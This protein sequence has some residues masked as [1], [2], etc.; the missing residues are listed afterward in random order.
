MFL[1]AGV[2]DSPEQIDKI[3]AHIQRIQPDR[4]QL[5]TAVRPTTEQGVVPL[6]PEQMDVIR[7][8]LGPDAEVIADFSR[9]R[10]DAD[11]AAREEEVLD[12]IRRRPVTSGDIAD[13]LG[14]H[15]NEVAKFVTALLKSG[16]IRKEDRAEKVYFR[17]D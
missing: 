3:A 17:A 7:R 6:S 16:R 15:M 12:M 14:I 4:I 13:G 5:N 11:F 9:A 1:I 8:Q 2:N 10:T